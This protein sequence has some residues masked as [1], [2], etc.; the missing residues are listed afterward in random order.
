M[1]KT[2]LIIDQGGQSTRAIIFD[3]RGGIVASES[4]PCPKPLQGPAHFVE[5]TATSIVTSAQLMLERLVQ[6]LT[7]EQI[8]NIDAVGIIT[9]RSSIIACNKSTGQAITPM[10]SWQ[11]TRHSE[12][13]SKQTFDLEQLQ[14]WTGLRLSAH[15][16]VSKMRWLLDY[17]NDVKLCAQQHNLLFVPWGAY[18]LQQLSKNTTFITDPILAARTGLTERGAHIWSKKLL[19]LFSIPATLLPAIVPSTYHY[20]ELVLRGVA[21]PIKLLGGDQNFIPCAYGSTHYQHSAFLNI[22]TGAFI[23]AASCSIA[24]GIPP[25]NHLLNTAIAIEKNKE[26]M[27]IIEGTINAAATVLDWWQEQL[28]RA[29]THAELD[30]HLHH[31]NAAPV[32]VNTLVGT[33]SPYW[34]P[35]RA[36]IFIEEDEQKESSCE[37]KTVAVIESILF[38]C[39]VNL[40]I[41]DPLVG[42]PNSRIKQLVIS[43]GLAQSVA[44][45]QK[46]ADL[47]QIPVLRY[48]DSEASARGAALY[49]QKSSDYYVEGCTDE[50]PV[51]FSPKVIDLQLFQRF[52]KYCLAMTSLSAK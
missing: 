5:Y 29:Y 28:P 4:V 34:I 35:Q 43:G 6:R 22:G 46:L 3:V 38:A 40:E 47:V 45:C 25:K 18:F 24:T 44:L 16:G 36:P 52:Q 32:F 49:L 9:Q 1:G 33:G 31:I 41:M 11:D 21:I 42:Q 30:C 17:D 7:I 37:Q 19:S 14:Q 8:K 15:A 27:P 23:Q 20:G 51:L 50:S 10:I 48:D 13:L 26:L 39:R 12:W 2:I